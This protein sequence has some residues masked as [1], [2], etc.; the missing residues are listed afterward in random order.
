M[1]GATTL[2]MAQVRVQTVVDRPQTVTEEVVGTVRSKLRARLEARLSGRIEIMPVVLGDKLR[3]GQ[4]VA[5]L[6]AQEIGA[7]LEQAAAAL[8]ETDRN[9]KRV[10]AL[11][12]QKTVTRAEYDAA[13]LRQRAA[14]G[15][16]EESR[17]LMGYVEIVAPF[18]GC[19]TEKWA[20]V[21]DLASPGKPVVEIEDASV[22]QVE[23]AV[24]E[25]IATH[26][27]R[28]AKLS[29]RTDGRSPDV[30][31]VITEI[32]PAANAVSRTF[33]IKLDLPQGCGL[34]SGQFARVL[35]P[36]G[37]SNSLRVPQT[38]LV[39]RGQLEMVFSMINQ[40]A[41][42]HLVKTGK[43]FGEEIEILSGVEPGTIVVI[44]GADPLTDGQPL[45]AQ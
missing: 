32:S 5:R 14:K 40:R 12:D 31:G 3:K 44:S 4:L 27:L 6:D 22:L 45:E 35:V 17:T 11:Y 7:R 10:A 16:F 30:E 20:D 2:P 21:G 36:I 29:I 41:R 24:P 9:W 43:R 38:A 42:M 33:L 26:V 15:A 1:S 18:D 25:T 23:A 39:Q 8:E 13:Q 28:N 34:R 37:E 19:V